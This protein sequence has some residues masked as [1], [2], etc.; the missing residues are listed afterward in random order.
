MGLEIVLGAI[1]P[2]AVTSGSWVL[3]K[4][5]YLQRPEKLTSLMVLSFFVK[6]VFFGVYVAVMVKVVG[7]RPIPFVAS[8]TAAFVTLY[9]VEAIRLRQLFSGAVK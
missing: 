8:F 3:I 5:T 4:R 1:A 2:L 9:A 7:L 6:M